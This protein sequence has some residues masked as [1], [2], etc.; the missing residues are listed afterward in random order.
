MLLIFFTNGNFFLPME[1]TNQFYNLNENEMLAL[2]KQVMRLDTPRRDCTVE[3]DDGI[4]LDA[5]LLTKIKQWY[6][7]LLNTAPAHLLPIEDVAAQVSLTTSRGV[8]IATPPH[9]CVRPVE[10]KLAEW[11]RS[12]TEFL[13]PCSH[14]AMLQLNEWTRGGA[15]NP[16]IID[17][18]FQ[19]LMMTTSGSSPQLEL[20]RCVVHPADGTYQFH[21]SLLDTI[22]DDDFT[23]LGQGVL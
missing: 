16:A 2:W 8:V 21:S 14:E 9:H 11:Q 4:D 20:A 3:W 5:L 17:Y 23:P 15:C 19:L 7:H 22:K 12:V 1:N 13:D 18:G 6:A 10:W